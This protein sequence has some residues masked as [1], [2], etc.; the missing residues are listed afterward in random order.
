[1]IIR[2]LNLILLLVCFYCT[3]PE[4]ELS[5]PVVFVVLWYYL[6]FLLICLLAIIINSN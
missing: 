5:C 2:S 4:R 6:E 3:D 1:M